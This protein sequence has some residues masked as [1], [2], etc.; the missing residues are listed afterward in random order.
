MHRKPLLILCITLLICLSVL[1][2]CGMESVATPPGGDS[3]TATSPPA[4]GAPAA[5]PKLGVHA[6]GARGVKRYVVIMADFP[7][8]ERRFSEEVISRRLL[9]FLSAYFHEASYGQL[10]LEG[11]ITRRYELPH[12]VSYY[13]ISPRNLEVDRTRV[14]SLVNDVVNAADEE[15]A[16][17][18]DLLVI[19]SLGATQVEY[20]MI[21]Y[22]AVPGMLGF[23]SASPITTKSGEVIRNAV[24]FCENAHPG[25]HIH[26]TLHMLGGVVDGRRMA[27]CLYDHDIQAKITGGDDWAEVLINMGYWDPLSSHF[28]YKRELP[29]AGLS[30]WTK[31]RLGWIDPAKIALVNPGETATIQLD[32]LVSDKAETLVI[33]IPLSENAYYLVENRQPIESDA[34]LPSSGILILYADDR[35]AECRHRE[36][37]VRIMDANP[38]V[39]YFNDA[40]FDIGKRDS[41]IDA[42][43]NLAIVLLQ[44]DGMSYDIQ[45]TTPDQVED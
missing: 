45:V 38:E 12:P 43:N 8:L 44:K 9:G 39:P 28:P 7:D 23:K 42:E 15:V 24:V 16:F 21:G 6:T 11:E 20:G 33:K 10:T 3:E 32:P 30:S 2:A 14:L 22:C 26:D 19:I 29:P 18:E 1:L 25:T 27:P 40:A 13:E 31:L 5:D 41:F 37:P 4:V 17:S 35:V 34:N 36:A